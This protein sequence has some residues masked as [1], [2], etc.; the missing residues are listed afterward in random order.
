MNCPHRIVHRDGAEV[1]NCYLSSFHAGPHTGESGIWY[2][3]SH[4]GY[5]DNC[6]ECR[7]CKKVTE[8]ENK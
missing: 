1:A 6:Y 2:T 7:Y 5:G 4:W 3:V 8:G